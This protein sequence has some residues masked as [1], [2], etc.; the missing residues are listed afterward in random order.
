MLMS[1][2]HSTAH[3]AQIK[4]T[5]LLALSAKARLARVAVD[6]NFDMMEKSLAAFLRSFIAETI[7]LI[8]PL[9]REQRFAEKKAAREDM[10]NQNGKSMAAGPYPQ[11][12]A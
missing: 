4:A 7:E 9:V 3:L 6:D 2:R 12:A 11:K 1:A 8:D 5:S 10:Q